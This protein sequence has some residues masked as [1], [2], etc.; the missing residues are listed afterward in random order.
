MIQRKTARNAKQKERSPLLLRLGVGPGGKDHL[1]LDETRHHGIQVFRDHDH[2]SVHQVV[3][4]GQIPEGLSCAVG[5]TCAAFKQKTY[6]TRGKRNIR[7]ISN[8]KKRQKVGSPVEVRLEATGPSLR[9]EAGQARHLG[10]PTQEEVEGRR[11][12][13]ERES[14]RKI[15]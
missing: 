10:S 12:T 13:S 14:D 1:V 6:K 9:T 4:D 3:V 15:L 11:C 2:P 8:Q 7:N 5:C